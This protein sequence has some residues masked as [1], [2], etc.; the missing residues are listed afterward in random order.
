MKR[1]YPSIRNGYITAQD[2]G[3]GIVD[4]RG[5]LGGLVIKNGKAAGIVTQVGREL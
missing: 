3:F 2:S 1:E 4:G 5:E